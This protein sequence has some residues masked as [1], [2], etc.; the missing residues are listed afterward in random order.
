M[1]KML[2]KTV[3]IATISL[4]LSS[5]V[6]EEP[7][8]IGYITALGIDKAETGF[9]YTIQ[10]ANPT[11]ISGGAS[12]E[13]GSGGNIVENIVVE[14]PTIYSAISHADSIVSKDLSLS[15][16][17][18]I[19]VSEDVAREGLGGITDVIARN[20][21]IRPDV[22]IAVAE[23]AGEYLEGVKPVI[24]LNP[25][26][27]YQLTYENK[28]GGPVPQN[29]AGEFYMAYTSGDRDC[30]LPLAG[31]A[32]GKEEGG[33]T[34]AGSGQGSGEEKPSENDKNKE[35]KPNNGGFESGTKN[36]LP[37]EA[38]V[39]I[40][41]KGETM[42][43]A[44]FDGDTYVGKLGSSDADI[45][46]ILTCNI[47]NSK[48][49]FFDK[50]NPHVPIT[51]SLEEKRVPK[52]TIHKDSK[53]VEIALKL[54]GELLSAPKKHQDSKDINIKTGQMVSD[55]TEEFLSRIY[56]GLGVDLLGVRGKLKWYFL[57]NKTYD[58]YIRGFNAKEWTFSVTTDLVLKRTGMTYYY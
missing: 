16:A 10:F 15:H 19:V 31:V 43:L 30:A 11:K 56:G 2:F 1:I 53:T 17:K 34:D 13:G 47:K 5:C 22:Y 29:N 48:V 36:Y 51:I 7:N 24:E 55:A 49:S 41:N 37:G 14:A 52:I 21:D 58:E 4:F 32:G 57:S 40:K 27:Y 38:G 45:Y 33:K 26:K 20:N 39:E 8:D 42:G 23:N 50:S 44:L 25:V 6:G 28:K 9:N 12:E 54:E 35:A 3:F 18:I 46:N